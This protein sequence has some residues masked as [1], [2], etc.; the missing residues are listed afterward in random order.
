VE[1]AVVKWPLG[2]HAA[3]TLTP[4]AARETIGKAVRRGL[5][6]RAERRPYTLKAPLDVELRFKNYRPAEVLSW[7]PG[8]ERADA[9]AVRFHARDMVEATRFVEFA[10]T[11][12]A[13]LEP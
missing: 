2:F 8:V 11:Y 12:Q 13:N 10:L 9:H 4:E 5:E 3:R 1:T 7:M 6:R